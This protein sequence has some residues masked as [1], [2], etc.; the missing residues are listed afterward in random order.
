[1]GLFDFKKKVSNH[2]NNDQ[3]ACSN[4]E[5]ETQYF[6]KLLFQKNRNTGTIETSIKKIHFGE[7]VLIL[8]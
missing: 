6:G 3:E 8:I 4:M 1:M 2:A 7:T 5:I